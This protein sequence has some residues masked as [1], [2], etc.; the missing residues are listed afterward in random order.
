MQMITYSFS[1]GMTM[2]S[3][4]NSRKKYKHS[5]PS[6]MLS[7]NDHRENDM[8]VSFGKN[9]MV[10]GNSAMLVLKSVQSVA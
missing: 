4:I 10:A 9:V 3:L 2:N 7:C 8:D 1:A 5:G 6:V